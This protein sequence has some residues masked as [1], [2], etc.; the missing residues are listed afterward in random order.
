MI[1]LGNKK[2]SRK[3]AIFNLPPGKSCPNSKLCVNRCYA[4][5]AWRMYPNVHRAWDRNMKAS[6]QENFIT[7]I[8][9]ELKKLEHKIT[10][11]RIHSAGD[12]Y[13]LKYYYKWEC[14]ADFFPKLHFF[15]YTKNREAYEAWLQIHRRNLNLIW[16]FIGEHLN[17]GDREH[18]DH[19]VKEH[20]AFLCPC[21]KGSDFICGIDC[22]YCLT[23]SLPCFLKH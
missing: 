1:V 6:K 21:D 11:V 8:I 10:T 18:V 22:D 14:I 4:L 17:F 16:S 12:F 15:A 19:L 2:L 9:A 23:S 7:E 13:S 3:I 20:E 5:K